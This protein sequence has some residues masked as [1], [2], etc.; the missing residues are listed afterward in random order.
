[1]NKTNKTFQSITSQSGFTSIEIMVA[2]TLVMILTSTIYLTYQFSQ[3]HMKGWQQRM[4]LERT[5]LYCFNRLARDIQLSDQSDPLKNGIQIKSIDQDTI[6]YV[7]ADSILYR[8]QFPV[9][10]A[11][12]LITEMHIQ[13]ITDPDQTE[14][15][16]MQFQNSPDE[17]PRPLHLF[18][19]S[20]TFQSHGR[21]YVLRTAVFP[22]NQNPN[23]SVL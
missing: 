16:P 7:L 6:I 23:R 22:R 2:G 13:R 10:S 5:A 12:G 15:D 14:L 17:T 20:L 4:H 21:D 3:K 1:M 9:N 18:A 11:D 19:I 8:N